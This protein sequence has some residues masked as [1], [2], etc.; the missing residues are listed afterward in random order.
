MFSTFR[1]LGMFNLLAPKATG[2]QQ[3][4]YVATEYR[5]S[6][7]YFDHPQHFNRFNFF[8][9]YTGKLSERTQ[10]IASATTFWSKWDAS[11]QI[12]D[13]AVKESLVG[14][15][16]AIDPNEG[17]ITYRTNINAQLLTS[18][19]HGGLIKNQVYYSNSH[20]DLHSNFTFFLV[21][22]ING[23][24]IRQREARDMFGYNGSY[25]HT[26]YL[27]ETQVATE[28]GM[29]VRVDR[30]YNSE[31]SHTVNRYT[32]LQILKLGDVDEVDIAPY[33][34][35]TFTFNPK[36]SIN[37]GIRYDVFHQRYHNEWEADTAYPGAGIYNVLA[38]TVSP[39]LNV[40]YQPGKDVQ[41]YLSTGRGFHSNDSR[42]VVIQH[43]TQV[44]PAAFST[45]L[46]TVFKPFSKM[47]INAAIWYIDLDQEYVY[48]GDGGTVDF[49]GKTKRKGFDLS[50]RY[51]PV[52]SL[53]ADLDV[54][55]AHGRAAGAPKGQD[56]IP[57][58]PVWTSSAGLTYAHKK[59]WSGSLRYRFVGD[60]PANEDYSLTASGYFITDAVL[61]YT[62]SK[63]EVGLIIN[64]VF[65]QKWKETQFATETRL[66][67][68]ALPVEEVCFTPGTPFAARLTF[69]I[70]F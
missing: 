1:L 26:G 64:N 32:T 53:Y 52:T 70:N 62:H 2:K 36:W 23:D 37:A 51:E 34:G 35:A 46:G 19:P 14:F 41:L 27:G 39:K 43:G 10:L 65:N 54:N 40:Y 21:D 30:T 59:G 56:Y 38:G 55:Y 24:E 16:G 4:W 61:N 45:D 18:L 5:Y 28:G 57:L 29:Q 25:H 7:A 15:Y 69:T 33:L 13:R 17:G 68:E 6:N 31:L 66:K 63:Y 48:G 9:K 67:G 12:P 60:R 11:G 47:I 3:S 44:L 42:S 8:T 50:V 49:S 22:S 58:A 20:F